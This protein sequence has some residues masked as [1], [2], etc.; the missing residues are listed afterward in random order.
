MW[1]LK[2]C[3]LSIHDEPCLL[4]LRNPWRAPQVIRSGDPP[5]WR[6]SLKNCVSKVRHTLC[7]KHSRCATLLRHLRLTSSNVSERDTRLPLFT[8]VAPRVPP[9]PL[10]PPSALAPSPSRRRSLGAR[11]PRS[12]SSSLG[13]CRTYQ[14]V[15]SARPEPLKLPRSGKVPRHQTP[16]FFFGGDLRDAH[17]TTLPPQ[18][19]WPAC[20]VS[21]ALYRSCR[22]EPPR[23]PQCTPGHGPPRVSG[24]AAPRAGDQKR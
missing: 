19:T 15:C 24:R 6:L 12:S 7:G 11:R 3:S 10:V 17:G 23:T 2:L 8:P 1:A 18:G 4:P 5:F 13:S 9:R 21:L 16:D 20:F 14:S 22:R